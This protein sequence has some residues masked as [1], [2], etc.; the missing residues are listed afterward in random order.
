M[1][2]QARQRQ[3]GSGAPAQRSLAGTLQDASSRARRLHQSFTV[4]GSWEPE[5]PLRWDRFSLQGRCLAGAATEGRHRQHHAGL[6]FVFAGLCALAM[7]GAHMA[8][9]RMPRR[10]ATLRRGP[11]TTRRWSWGEQSYVLL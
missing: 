7:Q 9:P 1:I 6:F 3:A 11:G 5:P 4:A 10:H 8:T 2:G